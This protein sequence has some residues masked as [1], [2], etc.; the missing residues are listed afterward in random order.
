MRSQAGAWERVVGLQLSY[1]L[2]TRF[3]NGNVLIVR[4]GNVVWNHGGRWHNDPWADARSAHEAR[5]R[6]RGGASGAMRSQAGAWER[7]GG[8]GAWERVG[9]VGAWGEWE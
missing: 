8:A 3:A 5:L 6:S 7:V 4:V 2:P 1:A 9:G